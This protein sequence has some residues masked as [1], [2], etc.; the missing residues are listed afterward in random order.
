[1]AGTRG[2]TPDDLADIVA[3]AI[4]AAPHAVALSGGADSAVCA[5]ALIRTGVPVRLLHV[6]HRLRW[7]SWMSAGARRV[8]E[9]LE[10]PLQVLPVVVPGGAS[11]EGQARRV[12]YQAL[13]GELEEGELLATGHTADDQAETVLHRL[14]R[15]TGPTGLGGIPRYRPPLVRPLLEAR[16]RDVRNVAVAV[17]LPFRDDPANAEPSPTRN[18]L[19]HRLLPRLEAEYN[20]RLRPALARLAGLTAADEAL[21]EAR[22]SAVPIRRVEGRVWV[23]AG[24][25]QALPLAVARRVVRR[26]VG[27]CGVGGVGH[28]A[29]DRALAV[30]LGR[31]AADLERGVGAVRE[32][33]YL[34]LDCGASTQMSDTALDVP[35]SAT[36]GSHRL[37]ARVEGRPPSAWPLGSRTRVVDATRLGRRLLVRVG[38]PED[39]I[40]IGGGHKTL[41]NALAE[42]KVPPARR[43]RWPV[44]CSAGRLVWIA[45]VRSAAWAWPDATT[46]RFAWLEWEGS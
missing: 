3:E 33:A 29:V 23:P 41:L 42:A 38:R 5:W 2:L 40:D 4:I 16:R 35:G 11:P 1:M 25:L 17:G 27:L 43:R 22:V 26:A 21:I 39:T 9:H 44:A 7:S 28:A 15:G 36:F 8:A 12:R 19:R 13:T 34:V 45:G 18:R 46:R 20:P 32:G 37:T 14:L 6:D 24:P 31:P 30:A 10:L